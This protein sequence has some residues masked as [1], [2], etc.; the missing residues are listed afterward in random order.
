M[1]LVTDYNGTAQQ[2]LHT[3]ANV[4]TQGLT[5]IGATGG[6]SKVY[7][8]T[9]FVCD[10][11]IYGAG[12][13]L[14]DTLEFDLATRVN[15]GTGWLT[16]ITL[17]D[18]TDQGVPLDIYILTSNVS[19]GAKNSLP[20]ITDTDAE[21]VLAVVPVLSSDWKDL[22]GAKVAYLSKLAILIK[23]GTL[24][25]KIWISVVNGSGTPTFTA[26]GLLIRPAISQD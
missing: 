23:A 3:L 13:V 26:S 25:K 2:F 9:P 1:S 16:S 4:F 24:S 20:S 10:T 7:P 11:L 12:D 18:K 15:D 22:G 19:L 6:V 8:A 14:T 17:I 5:Y 21:N